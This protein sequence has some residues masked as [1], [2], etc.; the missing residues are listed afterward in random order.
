MGVLLK[1]KYN[2]ILTIYKGVKLKS[3]LEADMAYLLDF[4]E[5]TMD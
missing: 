4:L 2:A 5:L 1:M 3:R